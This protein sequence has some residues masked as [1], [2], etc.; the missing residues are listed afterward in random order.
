M[1]VLAIVTSIISCVGYSSEAGTANGHGFNIPEQPKQMW[2][3][4]CERLRPRFQVHLLSLGMSP[5]KAAVPTIPKWP[6]HLED[7]TSYP[8]FLISGCYICH[9]GALFCYFIIPVQVTLPGAGREF[10]LIFSNE[11]S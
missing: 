5:L 2:R 3:E 10:Y 9:P 1:Y 7:S 4:L 6:C 8:V 11:S